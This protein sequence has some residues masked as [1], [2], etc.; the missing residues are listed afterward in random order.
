MCRCRY[1][2]T[3]TLFG[4]CLP[5]NK[6]LSANYSFILRLSPFSSHL[7]L[8]LVPPWPLLLPLLLPPPLFYSLPQFT[9]YFRI[10]P[11]A[12]SVKF[13]SYAFHQF[14]LMK[15][16]STSQQSRRSSTAR[17]RSSSKR[18]SSLL[19]NILLVAQ[20]PCLV[21]AALPKV[22]FDRMGHVGLAGTF[23]G[24]DLFEDS[25][26]PLAL[27]PSTSTLLSRASDGSL[28]RLG[29]TNTDGRINTGCAIGDTYF[30]AGL[31]S[32]ID[33]TTVTNVA[34]FSASSQSFSALGGS[35]DA[36][37]GEVNAIF[38][39]EP[40]KRVWVG[41]RFSSPASSC[42]AINLFINLY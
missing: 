41:G 8:L 23:A 28:T 3:H 29:S 26:S 1:Q 37:N 35:G 7:L 32:S 5:C 20:L 34:S 30:F 6:K 16:Q 25:T 14:T 42:S 27:D 31:F 38:C 24:L 22:D 39:D 33:G 40:N 9:A 2:R 15:T 4:C 19:S 21:S 10:Y 12:S 11:P 17:F 18:K 36:P 13:L